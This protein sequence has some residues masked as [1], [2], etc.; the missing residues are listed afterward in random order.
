MTKRQKTALITG[1][2]GQDGYYLTRFLVRKGYRVY[3]FI[4]RTSNDPLARF[5]A[6]MK[7]LR[8]NVKLVY[9]NMRDEKTLV[10]IL[11]L[12]R[13]DEIYNLAAQSDVGIS[14]SCPDE[15]R[16]I[17]YYGVGRLFKNALKLNPKVRI[18]QASTSEMFGRSLP[19]QSETTSFKPVSPYAKSKLDAHNDF[20]IRL[21]K[22]TNSFISSGILF[23]HESPVRGEHFVTRKVTISLSKI[24]LGIQKE[25][26]LGNLEAKR[27]W[28][29]AGDYV[30][31]MWMMLQTKK[32]DDYVVGSGKS[33][34]V[35]EFVEAVANELDMP[36]YW[37][38]EG[39]EEVGF[40]RSGTV[41]IRIN[42]EYYRPNEVDYL[43]A[44]TTKVKNV[45]GWKPKVSFSKLVKMM[46]DSDYA[47][48]K[49]AYL[50]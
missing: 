39:L 7:F 3:G 8:K 34:T 45:L 6:E 27:D 15:T 10:N 42:K 4:R 1:I 29:F 32:P 14:F 20:V 46:V 2:T 22:K 43:L 40:D 50:K 9:G 36:I 11:K 44:D 5:A 17:N 41:R 28:G 47:R 13:P 12:S 24:K 38:G 26:S 35:R 30:K 49:R 21:R 23:N 18:Y 19:P 48:L 33:R 16:D 31:A 37:R 25:F